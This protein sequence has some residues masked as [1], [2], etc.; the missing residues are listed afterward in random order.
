M[1]PIPMCFL[2]FLPIYFSCRSLAS[3]MFWFRY[4]SLPISTYQI[5]AKLSY[6]VL[7]MLFYLTILQNIV[8]SWFISCK[9][10]T[11]I[12][13]LCCFQAFIC[14]K[15]NLIKEYHLRTPTYHQKAEIWLILKISCISLLFLFGSFSDALFSYCPVWELNRNLY[16]LTSENP[17]IN[18]WTNRLLWCL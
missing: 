11:S 9:H 12:W 15:A 1:L 6:L 17:N 2:L 5:I 10:K 14:L 7:T 18:Y 3:L 4:F 16:I 13:E 8:S